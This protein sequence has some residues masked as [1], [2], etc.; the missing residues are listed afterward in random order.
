[1]TL[2]VL[3]V[4]VGGILSFAHDILVCYISVVSRLY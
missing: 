3:I 1:M 2:I 4:I